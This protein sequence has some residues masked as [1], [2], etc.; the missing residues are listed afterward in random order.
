ML[1]TTAVV[2]LN[3]LTLIATPVAVAE[4]ATSSEE[5]SA[6]V[7]AIAASLTA[8][9]KRRRGRPPKFGA[10]ARSI[11]MTLPES[12]LETL[13]AID[14][15]PSRAIVQ[16]ASRKTVNGRPPAELTVFGRNAVITVRPSPSLEHR[17]GVQLV[18]LP[19]GRALISFDRA[20]SI[21]DVELLIADALD[22]RT[23][24]SDDRH[25]FEGVLAILKEARRSDEIMLLRRNIIVLENGNGKARGIKDRRVVA[26]QRPRAR[27]R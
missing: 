20:R 8:T 17:A 18:P 12:T 13:T 4:V 14:P 1:V 23:L 15:D 2:A 27:T 25:V 5:M 22:D 21:A 26:L 24:S 7:A 16:L 11:T 10:P 3:A 6:V 19:D 9:L